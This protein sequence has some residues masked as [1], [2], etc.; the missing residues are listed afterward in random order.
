M[1]LPKILENSDN[2]LLCTQLFNK[3]EVKQICFPTPSKRRIVTGDELANSQSELSKNRTANILT[4]KETFRGMFY[5]VKLCNF[6]TQVWKAVQ[7][8]TDSTVIKST[9]R[10]FFNFF[11]FIFILFCSRRLGTTPEMIHK[12]Y[13]HITNI[14]QTTAT[15][16]RTVN[17]K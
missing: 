13:S 5:S 14:H 11:V 15:F 17:P 4:K 10:Y 9:C 7:Y 1:S 16:L 2:L 3:K 6:S 8:S 12:A